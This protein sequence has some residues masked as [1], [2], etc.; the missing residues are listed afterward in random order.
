MEDSLNEH[1]KSITENRDKNN[2]LSDHEKKMVEGIKA[3][4]SENELELSSI[5]HLQALQKTL[6]EKQAQLKQAIFQ[7]DQQKGEVEHS[8]EAANHEKYIN[9]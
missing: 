6:R 9:N 7:Q 1:F 8:I 5:Q 3:V 2:K 4:E